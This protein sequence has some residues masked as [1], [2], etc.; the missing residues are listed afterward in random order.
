MIAAYPEQADPHLRSGAP[1]P[2]HP[3]RHK[4]RRSLARLIRMPTYSTSALC[5]TLENLERFRH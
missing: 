1:L 2:T 3:T 5:M 4:A